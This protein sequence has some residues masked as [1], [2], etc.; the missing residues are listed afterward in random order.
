M[1]PPL[2]QVLDVNG[3]GTGSSPR[4][5]D[6][7][8]LKPYRSDG[9]HRSRESLHRVLA[10]SI[11]KTRDNRFYHIHGS[12]NPD[13]TLTA[14]GLPLEGEPDDTYEQV[15]QRF[16]DKVSQFDAIAL[17]ELMNEQH[18]QA[19]TIAWS[20][21]EYFASEHGRQNSKVGLYE[22]IRDTDSHQ[23]ATWWPDH[24]SLPSSPE[25]PLA[26]LK[27]VDLTRVIAG[28]T[29][30]RSLA[31][32]GASIMR[33]TSPQIVDFTTVF[34]DLNWGKWN[35][36]LHL[37]DE[38]DKKA[39]RNL[40][41]DADVVVDGYRPGVMDKLGFSRQAIFDLVRRRDRGI[42]HVRENCYGWHGP[43]AHRSG[44][45]GISD[46]CC[47]VSR[48]F[49]EG[50]GLNEAVTPPFPNSDHCTGTIGSTAILQALVQ[51]SSQGG[52]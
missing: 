23:P 40:I 25:R 43:W 9:Y 35:C 8:T 7:D 51:R 34:R 6:P 1:S 20:S 29:I 16:Q 11:Y 15:V 31:E 5:I 3:T 44:W 50:M 47:G 12:L 38:V 26:G 45:Q 52:S 32:L 33:V 36:S 27:V 30:T 2:A 10:T 22:L 39:L 4:V 14:L 46:A 37:T 42:I 24:R 41:L 18:R 17:D 48:T 49:A 28:P 21:E 13:Q 19:G